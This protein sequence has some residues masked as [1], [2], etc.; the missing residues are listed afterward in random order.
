[1]ILRYTSKIPFQTKCAIMAM[2]MFTIPI[3][4]ITAN[5]FLAMIIGIPIIIWAGISQKH[6]SVYSILGSKLTI[7]TFLITDSV[8]IDHISKIEERENETR[9]IDINGHTI[10]GYPPKHLDNMIKNLKKLNPNIQI[11]RNV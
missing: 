3:A 7:T 11:E 8:L 4:A 6:T 1:M 9:V 2:V 10:K 5:P